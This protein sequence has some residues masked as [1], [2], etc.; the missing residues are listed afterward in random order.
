MRRRTTPS[1]QSSYL[2]DILAILAF[3]QRSLTE[4][5]RR[6]AEELRVRA[7]HKPQ[8]RRRSRLHQTSIRRL[9]S[10][11]NA[12]PVHKPSVEELKAAGK[13]C[14]LASLFL[15]CD[16]VLEALGPLTEVPQIAE[17]AR[18]VMGVLLLFLCLREG[19]PVRPSSVA[20][21]QLP[22]SAYVCTAL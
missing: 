16:S 2:F 3:V 1:T 9:A 15:H 14:D 13:T 4:E 17:A 10:Q 6:H 8:R 7:C 22:G 12:I 18:R 20:A 11:L 19:L 5:E 21:L